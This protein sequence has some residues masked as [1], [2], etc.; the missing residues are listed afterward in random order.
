MNKPQKIRNKF[1][2]QE[3]GYA[4]LCKPNNE[5]DFFFF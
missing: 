5:F 3:L 1:V 4:E 2:I